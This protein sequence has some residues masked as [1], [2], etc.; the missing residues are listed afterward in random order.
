MDNK[1]DYSEQNRTIA[2]ILKVHYLENLNQAEVAKKHGLSAVKVNR[3]LKIAR[4]LGMIEINIRLSY[5]TLYDLENQ[6]LSLISL[7]VFFPA[8]VPFRQQSGANPFCA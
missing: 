7:H 1:Y 2:K 5:T 8:G 6:L 4:Q 3:L